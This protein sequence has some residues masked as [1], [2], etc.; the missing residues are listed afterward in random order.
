MTFLRLSDLPKG[1]RTLKWIASY[2]AYEAHDGIHTFHPCPCERGAWCRSARCLA[3]WADVLSELV[4]K[5]ARKRKA[6]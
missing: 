6:A 5:R 3:C 2:I 1:Q 4:L